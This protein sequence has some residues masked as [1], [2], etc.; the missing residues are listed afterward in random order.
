MM[1]T[2]RAMSMSLEAAK[3]IH[4]LRRLPIPNLCNLRNLWIDIGL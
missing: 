3:I 2:V 4:R 1:L